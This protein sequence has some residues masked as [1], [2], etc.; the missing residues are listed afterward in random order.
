MSKLR[1]TQVFLVLCVMSGCGSTDDGDAQ[2][3]LSGSYTATTPQGEDIVITLE[4]NGGAIRVVGSVDD[5]PFSGVAH[6]QVM[7]SGVAMTADGQTVPIEISPS[8]GGEQVVL[9]V[10]GYGDLLLNAAPNQAV[11]SGPLTGLYEAEDGNAVIASIELRQS[12]GLISGSGEVSGGEVGVFG[13]LVDD[14]LVKAF[15]VFRDNTRANISVEILN[16]D[17]LAVVGLGGRFEMVRQ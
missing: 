15:V 9:N 8:A 4:Q 7:A 1:V 17:T 12:G 11:P 3:S 10:A 13:N 14:N 6:S 2:T 5:Q 16:D